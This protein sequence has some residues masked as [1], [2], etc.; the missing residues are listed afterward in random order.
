MNNTI[1]Y[2]AWEVEQIK[3]AIDYYTKAINSADNYESHKKYV[4]VIARL[5]S[6][7]TDLEKERNG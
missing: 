2:V 6:Q 7:L 1:V 4:S 3:S 5:R